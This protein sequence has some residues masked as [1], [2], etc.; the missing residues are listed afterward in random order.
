MKILKLSL[1]AVAALLLAKP[2]LASHGQI[3]SP[4]L[5]LDSPVMG[6]S[7]T[8]SS[9]I[10]EVISEP[11]YIETKSRKKRKKKR[12]KRKAK[13][14]KTIAEIRDGAIKDS[15]KGLRELRPYT[16]NYRRLQSAVR[17][18]W[19]RHVRRPSGKALGN[20]MMRYVKRKSRNLV[21]SEVYSGARSG[22]RKVQKQLR[23]RRKNR[24]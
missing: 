13:K 19:R 20:V 11:R 7:A 8:V 24:K 10:I 2:A 18:Y 1:L 16:T 4:A 21:R 14:V 3:A 12:K 17:R 15:L 5:P 23:K 6:N 9:D 22:A